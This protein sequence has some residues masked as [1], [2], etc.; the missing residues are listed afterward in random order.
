MTWHWPRIRAFPALVMLVIFL[1]VGLA[2]GSA[3]QA[4]LADRGHG[5]GM[6]P[7]VNQ[8]TGAL[9]AWLALPTVLFVVAN[10]APRGSLWLPLLALHVGGYVAF[11]ALHVAAIRALR[12]PLWAVFSVLP[13][14]DGPLY[15]RV[16][17][18]AQN[19]LLVYSGVA[20]LFTLLRVWQERRT[21]EVR[22]AQLEAQLARAQLE[23]VSARL[24]PHFLYNALN[25]VNAVM[26]EDLARTERLLSG[27]GHML[28]IALAPGEA[29]WTVEEER[30]YV[31]RYIELL[32]ARFEDR[33]AVDWDIEG[34]LDR[35]R[36][37]RFAIQALV[38]NSAKHNLDRTN[39]LH[40]HVRAGAF[41]DE[42]RITVEDDGRGFAAGVAAAV[43]DAG[44][45]ARGLARLRQTLELLHGDRGRLTLAAAERG[46]AR[47]T[48]ELPR[49]MC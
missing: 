48:L 27:L 39:R 15:D 41:R 22:A 31:Q 8:L 9:A 30:A 47:V 10:V 12:W 35:V 44:T 33:I 32:D 13:T 36:I 14:N 21:S 20:A 23:A 1:A 43:A 11:T 29:T 26:H 45:G 7:L 40:V 42:L 6:E 28:R 19:D 49:V 16:L 46:G 34:G 18:E 37:P 3:I 38:E 17:W 25:T 24:D 5:A 4:F 2:Q